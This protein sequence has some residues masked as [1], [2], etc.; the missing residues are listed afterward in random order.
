MSSSL[1][2]DLCSCSLLHLENYLNIWQRYVTMYV[3]THEFG[4]CAVIL[5]LG[6]GMCDVTVKGNVT[7]YILE[8]GE[9][10]WA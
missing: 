1:T 10:V 3:H 5:S 8:G 2:V 4:K 6:N 9:C 7:W